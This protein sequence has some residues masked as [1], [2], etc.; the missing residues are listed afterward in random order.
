MNKRSESKGLLTSIALD[1]SGQGLLYG[2]YYF[3][4]LWPDVVNLMFN[5]GIG[6]WQQRGSKDG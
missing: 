2:H 1:P 4:L 6:L 5:F 3:T